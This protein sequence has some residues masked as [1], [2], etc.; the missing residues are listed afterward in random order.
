M[1]RN[2][3]KLNEQS[4]FELLSDLSLSTLGLF[5]IIFVTY[6][7]IF[8]S[9]SSEVASIVQE[10]ETLS[11]RVNDLTEKNSQLDL[12]VT[13]LNE[14]LNNNTQKIE[15]LEKVQALYDEHL[16]RKNRQLVSGDWVL[17]LDVFKYSTPYSTLNQTSR[18][19]YYIHL[20]RNGNDLSGRLLGAQNESSSTF[21]ISCSDAEI[22]GKI[23]EED[24]ELFLYFNGSC[25]YGGVEKLE[26]EMTSKTRLIGNLTPEKI[27]PE[28]YTPHAKVKGY[29]R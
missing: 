7:I 10:N 11:D 15:E 25:C 16:E 13:E 6:T 14:E 9:Q 12:E 2:K 28:C 27:V 4:I 29:Q 8:N 20:A 1:K 5:L 21:G 17:E 18:A 3:R 23:D 24:V 22:S 19:E 26:G